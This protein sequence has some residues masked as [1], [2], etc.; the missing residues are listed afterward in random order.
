MPAN[1]YGTRAAGDPPTPGTSNLMTFDARVDVVHERLEELE[2]GADAVAQH[3][4]GPAGLGP[5]PHRDPDRLLQD[6]AA[7]YVV[8]H[9]TARLLLK[10]VGPGSVD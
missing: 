6:G 4:R 7:A 5:G 1:V 2:P 10:D 8:A 9:D 3:Q